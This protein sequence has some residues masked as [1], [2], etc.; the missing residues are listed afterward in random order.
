MAANASAGP[1]K[2]NDCYKAGLDAVTAIDATI[3][4]Q[5]NPTNAA[6]WYAATDSTV[7]F[8]ANGAR[9]AQ[10]IGKQTCWK[11]YSEF[12]KKY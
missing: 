4:A 7:G 5:I 6:A 12:D 3:Y 11:E 1:K 10:C 9:I 8:N 2:Y